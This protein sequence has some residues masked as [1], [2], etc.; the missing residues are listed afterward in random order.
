M[1]G[2]RRLLVASLVVL[3]DRPD[4]PGRISR[5]LARAR[6]SAS[7]SRSRCGPPTDGWRAASHTRPRPSSPARARACHSSIRRSRCRCSQSCRGSRGRRSCGAR[8]PSCSSLRS[9]RPGGCASRGCG[10]RSSCCGRPFFEGIVHTNLTILTFLAFVILFYRSSGSPW[11][12]DPRDVSRPDESAVEVGALATIIGAVKV[13]QPHAWLFVAPLPLARGGARRSRGRRDRRPDTA[14]HR[15][16]ALVRL[17][18]PAASGERP[19]LAVRRLRDVAVPASASSG[20]PWRSRASSPSGSSRAGTA[21]H[22]SGVLSTV[23][24]VSLHQ[25]G[26]LFM[27]PAMLMIRLEIALVAACF[28]AAYSTRGLGSDHPRHTS[29]TRARRSRPGAIR[30]WLRDWPAVAGRPPA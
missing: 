7:T 22:G 23:G 10:S 2:P 4:D 26:L 28:V 1:N 24:A 17:G 19:G 5:R 8:S 12:A 16:P 29:H 11:R 20:W 6:N 27:I 9:W 15:D 13:S 25:F 18:R 21:V 14:D 30:A 3:L